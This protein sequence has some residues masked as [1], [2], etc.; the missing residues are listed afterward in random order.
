MAF[1]LQFAGA[2]VSQPATANRKWLF[3]GLVSLLAAA[4]VLSGWAYFH[5]VVPLLPPRVRQVSPAVPQAV[6]SAAVKTATA[7]APALAPVA[8]AIKKI[9]TAEAVAVGSQVFDAAKISTA[10]PTV[11][12]TLSAPMSPAQVQPV[13]MPVTV[14]PTPVVAIENRGP[15]PVVQRPYRIHTD[16]ERLMLAGQTAF[17]NV[18]DMANNYPDAYGFQAGDFLSDAKLGAPLPVYTIEESD[19]AAYQN[20]MPL[21]PLLKP[22]KQ[23]VFPVLMGSRLCCMVEVQQTGHEYVPGKG[24]KLL[25]MA[26]AKIQQKWPLDEGYHPLL[27]VNPEVPGF[28]FT[29]PELGQPNLT[30]TVQMFFFHPAVSPAD[31]IL[32]SWR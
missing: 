4:G 13:A 14:M 22:P 27:V 15:A 8:P 32:A 19:R 30:D 28:Y 10:A 26:W 20:G 21:K 11:T 2:N 9:A 29:V 31:V 7:A 18:M 16:E 6:V 1:K 3:I 17:D 25:A 5:H 12:A 24:N 23:W